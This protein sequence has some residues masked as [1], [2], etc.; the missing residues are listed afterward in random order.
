M[1]GMSLVMVVYPL[2]FPQRCVSGCNGV[3]S[4]QF[5]SH[6]TTRYCAGSNAISRSGP[7]KNCRFPDP[8]G[9][10]RAE[11]QADRGIKSIFFFGLETKRIDA[12]LLLTLLGYRIV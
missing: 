4:I 11:P 9:D 5:G 12:V 1:L 10:L 3:T 2:R 6:N 7:A 8:R